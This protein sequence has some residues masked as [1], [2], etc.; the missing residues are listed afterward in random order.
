MIPN[1]MTNPGPSMWPENDPIGPPHDASKNEEM[2]PHGLRVIAGPPVQFAIISYAT[3]QISEQ[4]YAELLQAECE[5]KKLKQSN[6]SYECDVCGQ[7]A[8]GCN[9]K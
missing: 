4:R 2:M 1:D 7:S 3:V 5:L 6:K 8:F 9:C